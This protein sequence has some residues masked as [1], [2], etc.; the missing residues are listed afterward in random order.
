MHQ[1]ILFAG[2]KVIFGENSVLYFS[3]R[4]ESLLKEIK[5]GFL[6]LQKLFVKVWR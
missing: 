3:Q 1:F 6:I 5:E 2:K 4:A